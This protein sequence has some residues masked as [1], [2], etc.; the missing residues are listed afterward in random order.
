MRTP[1]RWSAARQER[2]IATAFEAWL[3]ERAAADIGRLARRYAAALGVEMRAARVGDQK[4]MWGTCGRDRVV[5]VNWRLV[6]AP[7][8]ALEYVVAHEVC[9]LVHRSHGEQFW[10]TLTLLMPDWEERKRCSSGGAEHQSRAPRL[11]ARSVVIAPWREPLAAMSYP[12]KL[13]SAPRS[14]KAQ[15]WEGP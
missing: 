15:P 11:K 9:H 12:S 2:E 1:A 14:G 10:A 6:Q 7:L 13:F 3:R 5:R 4:G 8:A